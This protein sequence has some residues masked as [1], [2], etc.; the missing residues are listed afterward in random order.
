MRYQSYEEIKNIAQRYYRDDNMCTVIALAAATGIAYGKAFNVYKRLGRRTGR[1][2]Y[3]TVQE[4]ALSQLGYRLEL[5]PYH[6]CKTIGKAA[7]MLPKTGAFWVYIKGHVA[8][9][10][11]GKMFDWSENRKHRVQAIYRVVKI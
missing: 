3:K 1:G 8:C 5:V 4:V 11:N 10:N 9:V 7:S 6:G 2:T